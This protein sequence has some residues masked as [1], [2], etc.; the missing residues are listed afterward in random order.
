MDE[1]VWQYL[2][3]QTTSCVKTRFE[4]AISKAG[5]VHHKNRYQ[6]AKEQNGRGIG[7]EDV[8]FFTQKRL[9]DIVVDIEESDAAYAN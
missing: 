7:E 1:L 2:V 3:R 5:F 6:Y 4:N 9:Q 8:C